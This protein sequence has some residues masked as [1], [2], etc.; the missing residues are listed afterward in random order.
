MYKCDSQAILLRNN[1]K[2]NLNIIMYIMYIMYIYSVYTS[3]YICICLNSRVR[4]EFSVFIEVM[5]EYVCISSE[6]DLNA[7]EQMNEL[8]IE[9]S[10]EEI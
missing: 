5:F 8:E 2:A 9:G 3:I 4:A 6:Y 7:V 10:R 1:M